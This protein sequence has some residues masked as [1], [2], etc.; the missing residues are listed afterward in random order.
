MRVVEGKVLVIERH[1]MLREIGINP[2][3]EYARDRHRRQVIL[4]K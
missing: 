3:V 4:P 2:F 1:W